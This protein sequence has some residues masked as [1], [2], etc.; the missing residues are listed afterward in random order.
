MLTSIQDQT[1]VI[2][3]TVSLPHCVHRNY[4]V[5]HSRS[6]KADIVLPVGWC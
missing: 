1:V 4:D 2:A 3:N 6:D 5:G